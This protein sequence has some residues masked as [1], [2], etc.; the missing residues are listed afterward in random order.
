MSHYPDHVFREYDIRGTAGDEIDEAFAY[1]LGKAFAASLPTGS[2]AAISVARDA[3]I[4]GPLLQKAVMRGLCDAGKHV[5]D[6]GMIPTPLAYYSVFHMHTAGCIMVTA[7]HNPAEDNGF[8]LMR[9]KTSLHGTDIQ[10]LKKLMQQNLPNASIRGRI[11]C[12]RIEQDYEGFVVHDCQLSPRRKQ[13][14]KLVIDAGN[15]P[16]GV[17]A[18]PLY[19]RMGCE[20][21]ELYCQPDGTFPNHHPD[22]TIAANMQD[23]SKKVRQTN[24]DLGI[25][26]D[27]DGDRIGVVDEQGQ[28]I[29]A[30]MLLLILA[31][32]VLKTSPG[33]CII[34]EIKSSRHLYE[35]IRKAGGKAIMWRT[36]HSL[37]KAKMKET[38]ALLA[39]EM[40]GHIFFADRFYGFDDAV[41]AG[42]RLLQILSRSNQPISALF[43]DI[44]HTE[45]TP[46]IRIPCPESYKFQC[47]QNAIKHFSAQGH[48]ITDIDGMRIEF[49]DGWGLLRASNTQSAIVL[50]FE[51]NNKERLYEIQNMLEGW[52]EQD[53]AG[54]L[55]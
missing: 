20:V 47:V 10:Q 8:K 19:R 37:I 50:R 17:I 48:H 33:A 51:A 2:D 35:G 39:G 53:I 27:G 40:S 12:H 21:I 22:P 32:D 45:V 44:A 46:E 11:S 16:S 5:I 1:R 18:A 34:S 23:L 24:S 25:A 13:P 28:M 43:S 29:W 54:K 26:F 7:S 6:L 30:D 3:R 15:G 49:E 9:G 55:A 42:A 14:L 4:S 41:Y 31:L 52:L 36:G 38:G